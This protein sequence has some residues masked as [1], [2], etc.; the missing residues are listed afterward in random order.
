MGTPAFSIIKR[1]IVMCDFDRNGAKPPE[2]TK[3]RR[4]VVVSA[5]GPT[6]L[7][8]PLSATKPRK[9]KRHHVFIE[10]RGYTSIG[11]D[12]WAKCNMLTHVSLERLDRVAINGYRRI[13][14]LERSDF[15]RVLTGIAFAIQLD[16]N[17]L[18]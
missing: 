11:V 17:L 4:V 5:F 10:A 16:K 14:Y 8:V 18:S 9:L 1:M 3:R 13:E 6:A 2:M 15:N 7:V 12:V